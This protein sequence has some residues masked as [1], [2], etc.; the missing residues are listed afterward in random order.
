MTI[1]KLIDAVT[2][3]ADF[4]A[5]FNTLVDLANKI[6]PAYAVGRWYP[7][8]LIGTVTTGTAV[9]ANKIR[10][11]PFIVP[12]DITISDLAVRVATA[13]AAG[14]VQ[15]AIYAADANGDPTGAALAKTGNLST[16]TASSD[17]S[18]PLAAP[19]ALKAGLYFMA[20]N[21]DNS[22]AQL[23]TVG[24]S[25]NNMACLIGVSA[26]A[27]LSPGGNN[28]SEAPLSIDQTF[29]TWPDLTGATFTRVTSN[30][31]ALIRFKIA[32]A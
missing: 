16:A 26:L 3:R 23:Q 2:T 28:N 11:L 20:V 25:N 27:D 24:Q 9:T 14:N 12:V 18:L 10:M 21:A 17:V 8:F 22:T 13:A 31:T 29:G 19:V 1:A 7:A 6:R 4:A 30:N 15:V 5:A 32:S